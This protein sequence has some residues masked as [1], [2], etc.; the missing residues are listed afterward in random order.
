MLFHTLSTI[1]D[2]GGLPAAYVNLQIGAFVSGTEDEWDYS[3]IN[4]GST[5]TVCN[6][7][8]TCRTGSNWLATF[9]G[10]AGFAADRVLF[11]AIAS[12]AAANI[13]TTFNG[14]D[15]STTQ[16]GWT[17]G[18]GVEAAFADNRTAKIEYFYVDLGTFNSNCTTAA[19]IAISGGPIVPFNVNLTESI[20][21]AG[22]NYK[23]NF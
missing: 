20:V 5:A 1:N 12:D 16:L 15:S 23:F 9:R 6:T 14:V 13:Q 2:H 4:T 21:R 7:T 8:G 22:I 19:C 11:Y 17:V 18:A 3:G 10:R